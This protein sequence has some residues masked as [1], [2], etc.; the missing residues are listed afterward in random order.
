MTREVIRTAILTIHDPT[1]HARAVLDRVFR[2]Y[3]AAYTE[4]LHACKRAY[5]ATTLLQW[6]TYTPENKK[7]QPRV[8][9][10]ILSKRLFTQDV[11]PAVARVYAASAAPLESRLR[12]SLRE[13]VAQTLL[14]YAVAHQGWPSQTTVSDMRTARGAATQDFPSEVL[15]PY[16]EV[17]NTLALHSDVAP[18]GM[19]RFPKRLHARALTPTMLVT[20]DE[21][22]SLGNNLRR[23]RQLQAQLQRTRQGEVISVP[24]MG[25]RADYGGGLYFNPET[26]RFYARLDIVG[27]TSHLGRAIT[28][29][30]RYIDIKTGI[31]TVSAGSEEQRADPAAATFGQGRRGILVPL[32]MGRWHEWAQRWSTTS[33]SGA[34]PVAYLPQRGQ[35][36]RQPMAATPV[37]ARLVR[38]AD[39]KRVG[40]YRYELQV[41]FRIPVPQRFP[42][43]T[44]EERPLL[45][46]NRGVHHLYAAVVTTPDAG[47]ALACQVASGKEL[48]AV[49]QALERRRQQRQRRGTH[50]AQAI[51]ARRIPARDQRQRHIGDQHCALAANEIV[52]LAL[53]YGAQVVMEDFSHFSLRRVPYH[54]QPIMRHRQWEKLA[55]C[56]A[57]RLELLGAPPARPVSA[58]YISQDCPRCG[59]RQEPQERAT[60][61]RP[62]MVVCQRCGESQDRD[63]R[64]AANVARRLVWIR[65]RSADKRAGVA[66]EQ[67]L[68]WAEFAQTHPISDLR[69]LDENTSNKA[70]ET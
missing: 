21:L 69:S 60:A 30:G 66:A 42:P 15:P 12:Q 5:D 34:A 67:R 62:H 51:E 3:T 16:E 59:A 52:T 14:S 4:C 50:G 33:E 23:E 1:R 43:I 13:H 53:R 28:A 57:E 8:S 46:L 65:Q 49:Q 40:G 31:V 61:E 41:A 55:K 54:L 22:A 19:P 17:E 27:S 44:P 10:R 9:A 11:A 7:S 70:V 25:I 18:R 45:A 36:P 29:R 37:S 39:P 38:R 35:D 26:N 32:E 20:L 68:S 58:Q 47:R 48:L 24:L 63:I 64:A 6:A 2:D 56:I